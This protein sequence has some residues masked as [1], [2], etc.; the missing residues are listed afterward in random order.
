M[1]FLIG[2]ICATAF[3][4]AWFFLGKANIK[5]AWWEWLLSALAVISLIFAVAWMAE[6]F[7]ENEPKPAITFLWIFGLVA[8]VLAGSACA[9]YFVRNKAKE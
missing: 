2:V 4:M 1:W 6:G 9:S 5:L 7:M 8:L 3:F